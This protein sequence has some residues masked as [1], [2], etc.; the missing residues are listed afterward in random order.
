MNRYII[1]AEMLVRM[2]KDELHEYLREK[3][4]T[5]IDR[6]FLRKAMRNIRRY[7]DL[8]TEAQARGLVN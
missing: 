5:F 7:R 2:T 8:Q 4:P 3:K 1:E 6:M